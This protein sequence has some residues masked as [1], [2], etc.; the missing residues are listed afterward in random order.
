MWFDTPNVELDKEYELTPEGRQT[1]VIIDAQHGELRSGNGS[2]VTVVSEVKGGRFGRIW[3]TYNTDH[4]SE[5]A[6]LIGRGQFKR[7]LLACGVNNAFK[8]PA[9]ACA[10]LDGKTFLAEIEHEIGND[11]KTRAKIKKIVEQDPF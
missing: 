6:K 7:L 2:G 10:A 5:K 8:T 4:T 1:M 9:E 11:E 3:T